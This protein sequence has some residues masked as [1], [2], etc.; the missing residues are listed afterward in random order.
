MEPY[1]VP[2]L[3]DRSR[4]P[5]YRLVNIG[6]ERLRGVTV[7]LVDSGVMSPVMPGALEPT[8]AIELQIRGEHLELNATL[9]VRWLRPSG[10]EYLWRVCF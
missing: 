10:D 8:Q 4:A 7:A 9:L 1:R 2:F 6:A 5:A 3:F